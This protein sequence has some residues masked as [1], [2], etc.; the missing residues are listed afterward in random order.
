ML[1]KVITLAHGRAGNGFG[2]VLR[3]LLRVDHRKESPSRP[4]PESGHLNLT[5]E[6]FWS[7]AEEPCGDCRCEILL[8]TSGRHRQAPGARRPGAPGHRPASR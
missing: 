7:A 2:P 3:Y 5:Q 8:A 6:P 4:T 1:A